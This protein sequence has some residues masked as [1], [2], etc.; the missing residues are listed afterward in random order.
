M[1]FGRE[2]I[3]QEIVTIVTSQTRPWHV[4][5]LGAG[6]MGKSSI[7][8]AV[9]NDKKI[10][11]RF[12][13][14]VFITYDGVASTAMT[15]QLFLERISSALALTDADVPAILRFLA[16]TTAL[17]VVDNAETFNDAGDEDAGKL[18]AV[19]NSIGAQL[20]TRIIFTTRNSEVV[21][22]NLRCERLTIS[23]L[24]LQASCDAFEVV[25]LNSIDDSMRN[26]FRA[27]DFHPLSINIL[28]N[29]AV[30]NEWSISDIYQTWTERQ[31]QVLDNANDK[32]RSL[33][34][35]I[36]ISIVSF[37][38]RMLVLQILRAIAFLPQGIHR[39]DF[40]SIFPSIPNISREVE[41]VSRSSLIYRNGDRMTML[42]PI[43]M[44]IADQYNQDLPYDDPVPSC[45]RAYY[46]SN[47]SY[48][49]QDFVEREHGNIDRLMHFDM[50]SSVYQSD[51]AIH[52]I[53]LNKADKFLF[54]TSVQPISLWPLLVS[55]T[56]VDSFS[57]VDSLMQLISL[58]LNQVCWIPYRRNGYDEALEKLEV[59]ESY[60]RKHS[61]VCNQRLVRCLQLKGSIFKTR[62]NLK[63]AT[64]ALDEGSS[65]ARDL[66]DFLHEALL[67]DSLADVLLLQGKV[68][69]AAS[70]YLSAQ[71]N[72][73][74]KHE[75]GHLINLLI[76]RSYTSISQNDFTKARL[77]L[78]KGMELDQLHNGE[79]MRLYILYWK[80]SCEGWAGDV[81][82][83]L[84]MLQEATEVEV[85]SGTAQFYDYLSAIRG[86]AYYE[87]RMGRIA[88]ARNSIGRAI[89]LKGESGRDF[90]DDFTSALIANFAGERGEAISMIQKILDQCGGDN[91]QIRAI[92]HSTLAE[93]LLIEGRDI[94]GRA[95][96]VQAK[97]ICD[98]TG[99]SPKNLYV[100]KLHWYS[101]PVEYD[102]WERFL[103][104]AL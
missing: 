98:E 43:R 29:A 11:S 55:E 76:G 38:D 47:L 70:L 84:K 81:A 49:A 82:A 73:E 54:C 60:C 51:V 41:A 36:E 56:Q 88:D 64:E 93:I 46:H 14:R 100:N 61:P 69:E 79:R 62:G 44:Y 89:A 1:F 7:A 83:A 86:R 8:K 72:Y 2:E 48:R 71:Q 30:I 59:A 22:P 17:L 13:V 67:N 34:V 85:S 37:K 58:C 90:V 10:E 97:A 32:Y 57:R 91:R 21:P 95:Q 74:A 45:I 104:D 68:I 31:V 94:D 6:G 18:L 75:Y 77:L 66:Q 3:V 9:L 26:I 4:A 92:Y 24:S 27:L 28:A 65:I 103:A 35:A 96:F 40:P 78:D 80:A 50:S 87:A 5:L 33:R 16:S 99:I 101:L 12:Q 102:G 52:S 42:A 15:F 20:S 53:V 25:Y 19:L 63:L 39:S 23:G